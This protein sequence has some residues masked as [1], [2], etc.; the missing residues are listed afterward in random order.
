MV[1]TNQDTDG[2]PYKHKYRELKRRLKYLVYEN[3]CFEADIRDAR[4]KLLQISREKSFLLDHLMSHETVTISDD[5]DIES[6]DYSSDD[7]SIKLPPSSH[8]SSGL[9]LT[10]TKSLRSTAAAS[11]SAPPTKQTT[12]M[13]GTARRGTQRGGATTRQTSSASKTSKT[14]K[15]TAK[16]ATNPSKPPPSLSLVVSLPRPPP[17]P[18][19]QPVGKRPGTQIQPAGRKKM[20]L[21]S[22]VESTSS[23]SSSDSDDSDSSESSSVDSKRSSL[24]PPP[25]LI[26]SSSPATPSP[27][28]LTPKPVL[29][30]PPV[31]MMTPGALTTLALVPSSN[32]SLLSPSPSST[33]MS[34]G[35]NTLL[36][37]PSSSS[38]KVLVTVRDKRDMATAFHTVK[39]SLSANGSQSQNR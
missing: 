10:N 26:L 21:S 1:S 24:P 36:S 6:T 11:D 13:R 9:P 38:S 23:S 29:Q 30:S 34:A 18:A 32:L 7:E 35:S 19:L 22:P 28:V 14:T 3:E 20:K 31:K 5:S 15:M 4:A 16:T 8:N 25:P 33:S 12:R 17:V 27:T 39:S 37:L 2:H